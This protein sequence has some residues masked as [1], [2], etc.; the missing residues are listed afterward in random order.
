MKPIS[1]VEAEGF[2]KKCMFL[3]NV[4]C[5]HHS[6][7]SAEWLCQ[8]STDRCIEKKLQ[9]V[10]KADDFEATTDFF[11]QPYNKAIYWPDDAIRFKSMV[12][13]NGIYAWRPYWTKHRPW[14][15][16]SSG[17]IKWIKWEKKAGLHHH[18]LSMGWWRLQC[19]R[20]ILHL[21][22]GESQLF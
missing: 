21:A 22:I 16:W 20:H 14:T 4:M 19:F 13:P 18:E 7:I 1:T 9:E 12:S 3:I 2:K 15:E 11:L 6:T 10:S 17:G 5:Y 8:T